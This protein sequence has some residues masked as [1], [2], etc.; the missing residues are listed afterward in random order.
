MP[1]KKALYNMRWGSDMLGQ[2]TLL[3]EYKDGY[4]RFFDTNRWHEIHGEI[5]EEDDKGFT[6]KRVRT[7]DEIMPG[8][9]VQEE[10]WR[11]DLVDLTYWKRY[12]QPVV[13]PG[14]YLPEFLS[15][16]D[17]WEYYRRFHSHPWY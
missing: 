8:M 7:P 13:D 5:V 4:L 3:V 15:T 16:E 10:A 1:N 12:V 2:L 17:L 11:F 9:K 14:G 6:F